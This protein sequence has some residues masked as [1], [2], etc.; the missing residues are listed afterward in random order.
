ML[1]SG[2]RKWHIA[3]FQEIQWDLPLKCAVCLIFSS[4]KNLGN[5]NKLLIERCKMK[6]KVYF[7]RNCIPSWIQY[8][9][10]SHQIE[11]ES[12]S[13]CLKRCGWEELNHHNVFQPWVINL[14]H[15][16]YKL[17]KNHNWKNRLFIFLISLLRYITPVLLL[18][19]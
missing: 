11:N 2:L 8:Q 17:S 10:H 16:H 18:S 7:S 12:G 13:H 1:V 5:C 14:V 9:L 15:H 19:K 3:T 4:W 6:T